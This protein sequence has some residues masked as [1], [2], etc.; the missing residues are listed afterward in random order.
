[1]MRFLLVNEN[2]AVKKIFNI[3]AKKA[4]I[5]LDIVE[6][7]S[8]IPLDKDYGCI[9][10]DDEVLKTGNVGDFKSKMITTKFCII[11]SKNS[12]LIGG[13]ESYIRNPY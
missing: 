6:N 2:S 1:M 8:D 4:G 3:T 10:V 13:F 9:F 12:P 11:L 7:I 5:E